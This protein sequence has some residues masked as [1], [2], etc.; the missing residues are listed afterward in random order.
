MSQSPLEPAPP[1]YP[2]NEEALR[3]DIARVIGENP[4]ALAPD[5]D[6]M[7]W[8]LDSLRLLDLVTGWNEAGLTL[9]LS[10][11]AGQL[12]LARMWQVISA[13]QPRA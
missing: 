3:A 4:Q 9:D 12:T 7:D 5:D 13:R 11:L 8:G 2:R 10:E 6:L 1:T